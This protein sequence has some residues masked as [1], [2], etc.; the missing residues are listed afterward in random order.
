MIR[1]MERKAVGSV[2]KLDSSL[3]DGSVDEIEF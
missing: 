3:L 1:F 2:E